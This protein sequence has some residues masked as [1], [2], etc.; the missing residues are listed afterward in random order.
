MA[1]EKRVIVRVDA[2]KCQGHGRCKAVAA[3]LFKLDA[4]G[5]SQAI[6]DGVVRE[7]EIEK[8]YLAKAN[9]PEFAVEIIEE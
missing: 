4:Y 1:T 3:A 2:E 7:S 8:A 5:N 6:G 9:C